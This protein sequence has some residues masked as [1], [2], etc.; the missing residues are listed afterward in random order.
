MKIR[1]RMGIAKKIAM[2]AGAYISLWILTAAIGGAQ[3]RTAVKPWQQSGTTG[4]DGNLKIAKVRVWSP[5]PLVIVA[6]KANVGIYFNLYE[7]ST[8]SRHVEKRWFVWLLFPV[9]L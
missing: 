8:T 4:V 9:E 7:G 6:E 3:V 2:V 5:G 1:A